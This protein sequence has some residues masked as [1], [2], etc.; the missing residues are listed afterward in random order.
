M[1]NVPGSISKPYPIVIFPG[2]FVIILEKMAVEFFRIMKTLPT[3]QIVEIF[4][5]VEKLNDG[6]HLKRVFPKFEAERSH[7]RGVNGCSNFHIINI[8][9]TC[10]SEK[11]QFAPSLPGK[12]IRRSG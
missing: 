9:R 2:T 12:I 1:T 11:K 4:V 3:K 8:I 10:T 5:D 6:D 7:P